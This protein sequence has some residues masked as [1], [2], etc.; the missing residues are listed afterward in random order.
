M[1]DANEIALEGW[2]VELYLNDSLAH[3][4]RTAPDGIYR[5]SGI[6]PNYA[7]ADRYEMRFRR[8]GAGRD[9]GDARSRALRVHE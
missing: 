5:M 6:E 7:T 1:F 8:P 3:V 4:A 9:D 2:T